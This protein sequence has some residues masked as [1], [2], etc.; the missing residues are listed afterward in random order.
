MEE[1]DI[2]KVRLSLRDAV[3]VA[4]E[5]K[6]EE[7]GGET[8]TKKIVI[9]QTLDGKELY[10]LTLVTTNFNIINVKVDANSGDVISSSKDSIMDLGQP[11]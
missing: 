3:K 9:L 7:H 4:E 6:N 2:D 10:N 5:L 11:M 8:V 1:L